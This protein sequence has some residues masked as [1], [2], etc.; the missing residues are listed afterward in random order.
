MFTLGIA[1]MAATVASNAEK[2]AAIC[3]VGR[4]ALHDLPP[5][6][7]DPRVDVYYAS[8]GMEPHDLLGVCPELRS[9]IPNGYHLADYDALKRASVGAPIPGH[10][11]RPA[12]IYSISVT[13]ISADLETATI[14]LECKCTGLCGGASEARYAR[15]TEG[16][17]RQGEF[18]TLWVS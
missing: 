8:T 14:H 6:N 18:R 12:Y 5:A 13:E 17:Q 4:V 10:F 2:S 9:E 3:D 1:L 16:W 7:R 11:T 15:T